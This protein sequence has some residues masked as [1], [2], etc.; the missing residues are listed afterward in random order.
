MCHFKYILYDLSKIKTIYCSLGLLFI[1]FIEI[2]IKLINLIER[3]IFQ[4]PA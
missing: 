3:Q 2:E 1:H 4:F